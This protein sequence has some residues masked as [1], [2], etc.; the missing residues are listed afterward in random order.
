MALDYDHI[1]ETTVRLLEANGRDITVRKI[2][3]TADNLSKPWRGKASPRATGAPVFEHTMKAVFVEP[4]SL[5]RYGFTG[6]DMEEMRRVDVVILV[7][8]K[9]F[10]SLGI[11]AMEVDEVYDSL[12]ELTYNIE[13]VRE[14]SPGAT[15]LLYVLGARR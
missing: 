15:R 3:R 11:N 12:S 14:L 4:Y 13:L 10:T 6:K 2:S 8:G 1:A 5:V 9:S 7:P